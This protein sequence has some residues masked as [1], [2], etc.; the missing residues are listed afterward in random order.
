MELESMVQTVGLLRHHQQPQQAY[1][2]LLLV[3]G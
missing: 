1:N 3:E 2:W